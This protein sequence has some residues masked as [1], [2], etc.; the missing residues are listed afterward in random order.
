MKRAVPYLAILVCIG[1]AYI[2]YLSATR[3]IYLHKRST[4]FPALSAQAAEELRRKAETTYAISVASLALHDTPSSIQDN[5][6][7]LSKIR[8]RVPQ[9]LWPVLDL[10]LAKD[11]A[12]MARLEEQSGSSAAQNQQLA[13]E[14]LRSLGWTDVS[15]S[16]VAKLGDE[17]LR[18]RFKR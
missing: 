7:Y 2:G 13:E 8:S 17:Q 12:M 18:S 16:V 14:R 15:D 1:F 6:N 9:E 5:V 10:R 11:Y 4:W 3:I